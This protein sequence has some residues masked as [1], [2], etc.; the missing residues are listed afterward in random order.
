M[1]LVN[2]FLDMVKIE[3]GSMTLDLRSGDFEQTVSRVFETFL[4]LAE[5]RNI[6]FTLVVRDSLPALEFD[7]DK[8]EL[9]LSYL[10]SNALKFTPTGGKVKLNIGLR[11]TTGGL[12]DEV[13]IAAK[14]LDKVFDGW[15]SHIRAGEG[16]GIGL[17]LSKELAK[18]MGGGVESGVGEGSAFMF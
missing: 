1:S 18:L 3:S 5:Q 11:A 2:Q 7:S 15:I 9:V 14:A 8:T 16:T 13:F 10:L 17:A 12:N 4:R 6:E